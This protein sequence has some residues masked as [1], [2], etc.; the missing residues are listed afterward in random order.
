[1]LVFKGYL[2]RKIMQEMSLF[3]F[4]DSVDLAPWL[5]LEPTG[6]IPKTIPSMGLVYLPINGTI[7]IKPS[8]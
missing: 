2:V 7:K 1:M 3:K 4:S 8:M 5:I 6:D